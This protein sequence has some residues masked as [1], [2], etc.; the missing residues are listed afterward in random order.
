MYTQNVPDLSTR[1]DEEFACPAN[2][3]STDVWYIDSGTSAHMT[4]VRE[5]F[6]KYQEEQMDFQITV[7][8]ITKCTPVGRGTIGFQT[9]AGTNIRATNVLHVPRLGMDLISVSRL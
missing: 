3:V 6:L 7:G 2:S 4:R 1:L 5:H 8:N 9:E